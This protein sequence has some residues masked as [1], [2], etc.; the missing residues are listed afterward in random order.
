MDW[1]DAHKNGVER[2]RQLCGLANLEVLKVWKAPG[3]E[4]Y[5]Y[6]LRKKGRAGSPADSAISDM[7]S[8]G[9]TLGYLDVII[10]YLI[11]HPISNAL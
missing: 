7:Q 2:V 4:M 6:L 5:Q 8:Q 10:N 11:F 3:S 1:F 9:D